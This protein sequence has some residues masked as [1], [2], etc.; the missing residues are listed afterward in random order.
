MSQKIIILGS[1]GSIGKS[2]IDITGFN[3]RPKKVGQI[4]SRK[5]VSEAVVAIPFISERGIKKFFRLDRNF[6]NSC[7]FFNF[8]WIMYST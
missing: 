2:L 6:V 3:T 8:R 1:T 4:A 7:F 5:V